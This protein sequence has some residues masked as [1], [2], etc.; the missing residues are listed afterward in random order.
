MSR[1]APSLCPAGPGTMVGA[2]SIDNEQIPPSRA[3]LDP[4]VL[5]TSL[6]RPG[7]LWREVPAR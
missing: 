7:G 1:G 5:R 3:P 4:V 2:M 6:I